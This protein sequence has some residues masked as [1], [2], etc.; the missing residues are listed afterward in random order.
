VQVGLSNLNDVGLI[1]TLM[2]RCQVA[3][4]TGYGRLAVMTEV[5]PWNVVAFTPACEVLMLSG[6]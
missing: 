2:R 6:S 1:K 3:P 5:V 4:S